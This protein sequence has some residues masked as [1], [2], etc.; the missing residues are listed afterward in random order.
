[1]DKATGKLL[2]H[3]Q[4]IRNPKYKNQWSRSSTDNFGWLANGVG[5]RIK[6]TNTIQFIRKQD[7]PAARQKD[8][9]YGQFVCNV[10]P[11]KKER[12]RTQFVVG[13]DRTNYPG[14]VA[15]PTAEMLVAKP[16][17][18]SVVLTP[19]DKFMTIDISNFYLMTPLK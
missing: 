19:G 10:R 7:V 16:L 11:E 1:M 4:L 3:R 2:N 17:F 12:H 9:T 13:G 8:V 14:E 6:G 15:T 5:R 18:N